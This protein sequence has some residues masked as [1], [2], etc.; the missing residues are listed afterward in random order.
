MKTKIDISIKKLKNVRQSQLGQYINEIVKNNYL[1]R[2]DLVTL[3]MDIS[4]EFNVNCTVKDLII[5]YNLNNWNKYLDE[6]ATN[7]II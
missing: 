4:E 3:A 5:F 6:I 7:I 2:K 1:K